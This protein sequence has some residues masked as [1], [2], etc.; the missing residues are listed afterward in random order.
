[1]DK[2]TRNYSIG[3]AALA[4]A[5]TAVW[6]YSIWSPRVWEINDRL[7][8]DPTI[9]AYPYRFRVRSLKNGIATIS[10]PRSFD[11]PAIS[12]LA[13]IHPGLASLSQDD[14]RSVAAQQGLIDAQK[15]AM[16]L[17]AAEPDVKDV[18]WELDLRWLSDHG[19]AVPARP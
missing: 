8:S 12:F 13:V 1:M 6:I 3:L 2:F 4:L 11:V 5:L 15:R 14:P 7:E 10:T 18:R 19:I 16:N 9:A 17:V